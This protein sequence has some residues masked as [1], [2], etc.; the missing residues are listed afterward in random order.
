[1]TDMLTRSQ[2]PTGVKNLLGALL[3]VLGGVCWGVSGSIGQYLFDVQGL[4]S[5]W[6]TPVRLG[7]SG[8][9]LLAF[10]SF[11]YGRMTFTVWRRAED[12]RELIL[13]G[14]FGVSVCQLLYFTTI[15]LST[16]AM[17]TILQDLSPV[18]ILL[19]SCLKKRRHPNGIEI[20]SIILALLGVLLLTSHGNMENL[21]LSLLPLLTGVLCAFTVMIYNVV[22]ERLMKEYPI[23]LLQGWAF[24]MGGTVFSLIFRIWEYPVQMNLPIAAGIAG[25]VVIGNL[26]AFP[27]YLLGVHLIGPEKGILYGFSEP[28]TAAVIGVVLLGTHFTIFDLLGFVLVFLMLF[29]IST[30]GKEPDAS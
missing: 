9:I 26:L 15:M 19:W 2:S 20:V 4:D 10:S 14:F 25:V 8:L 27:C 12:R 5:R 28:L 21:R 1:M 29:L 18:M 22:P 13:Y 6:L 11:R 24:L 7:I 17:G 23:F 3:A 30:A 16:A